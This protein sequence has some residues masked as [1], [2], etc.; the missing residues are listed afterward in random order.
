M[1]KRIILI[2]VCSAAA[3]FLL[4][5]FYISKSLILKYRIDSLVNN[6]KVSSD[7]ITLCSMT[8]RN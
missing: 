2:G 7:E 5:D 6:S 1:I 3:V 8:K 4:K